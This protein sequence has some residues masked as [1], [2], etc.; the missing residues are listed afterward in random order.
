MKRIVFSVLMTICSISWAEWEIT[1]ETDDRIDYHDRSTI[2]RNGK[3]AKMWTLSEYHSIQTD[4][5]GARYK[6]DKTFWA[7]NCIEGTKSII[8]L[9]QY[10]GSMGRGKT[11]WSMNKQENDLMWEVIPPGSAGAVMFKIACRNQ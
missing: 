3:I 7:F 6:S 8:A 4:N 9:L 2:R 1:G 5:T 10:S 11:V